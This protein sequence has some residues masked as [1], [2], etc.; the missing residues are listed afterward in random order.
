MIDDPSGS[1]RRSCFEFSVV[2]SFVIRVSNFN[3]VISLTCTNCKTTLTIDDAFAGGVCRC[4]HCGTIQTVPSRLKRSPAAQQQDA[5][6]PPAPPSKALYRRQ[7]G[8]EGGTGLDDLADAVASSGLSGSGLGAGHRPSRQTTAVAK[9]NRAHAALA[10][11]GA[12][13]VLLGVAVVWLA[14]HRGEPAIPESDGASSELAA[15]KPAPAEPAFLDIP[16]HGSTVIYLVD[17]GSGTQKSFG[18]IKAAVERSLA[19]LGPDRKFQVVFWNNGTDDAFPSSSP[20]YATRPNLQAAR[21]AMENI[22]AFGKT[23][24]VPA[25]TKA[26]QAKPD[27]I[28]LVTGK[29]WNLDEAFASSIMQLRGEHAPLPI[30]TIAVG[31]SDDNQVLGSIAKRTGGE[32]RELSE[33]QLHEQVQQ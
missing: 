16:L 9:A 8:A 2:S 28:V 17:R 21:R 31:G 6:P 1:S 23:D 3:S 25:M 13:I 29:A 4:Q 32:H 10:I 19:T 15:E 26:M 18:D 33:G 14:T 5:A 30:H 12:I 22:S 20:T 11:A 7:G 27:E 24:V